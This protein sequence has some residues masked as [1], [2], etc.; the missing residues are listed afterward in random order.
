MNENQMQFRV[1]LFVIAACIA[2]AVMIFQFGELGSFWQTRPTYFV[3]MENTGGLYRQSPVR[4]SGLLIGWV[5]EIT[6]DQQ[7]G[8]VLIRIEIDPKYQILQGS[9][10]TIQT[11]LLGDASMELRPGSGPEPLPPGSVLAGTPPESP[12]DVVNRLETQ[13]NTSLQSFTATS[14]EWKQVGVNVNRLLSSNEDELHTVL[15]RTVGSLD[16]FMQTMQQASETLAAA[17]E[18][19]GHANKILGDPQHQESLSLTINSLPGLVKETQTTIV[20]AREA[21]QKMSATAGN[22][23]KATDP[24]AQKTQAMVTRL[25]STLVHMEAISANIRQFT[26]LLLKE[27]GTL[28]RLVSDPALYQNLSTTAATLVILMRNLQPILKDV[29]V[30]TDKIARHPEV[31]GVRGAIQGSDGLKDTPETEAQPQPTLRNYPPPS[32]P[33]TPRNNLLPV[34]GPQNP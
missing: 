25:E 2:I 27:D 5:K 31:L 3:R 34:R 16:Q 10:V 18:T 19:V 12:L 29:S 22:L 30:F 23:E 33:V 13:V 24:L 7:N 32:M 4:Q 21:V 15:E 9:T 17:T 26:D 8:G 20:A 6:L 1:G 14:D 28:Q 11:T